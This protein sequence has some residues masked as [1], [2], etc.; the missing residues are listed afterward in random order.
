MISIEA[1]AEGFT[2]SADGR[3]VLSHTRKRPCIELGRSENLVRQSRGSFRLRRR[4]TDSEALKSYKVVEASADLAIV[5]FEGKLRVAARWSEGRLRLSFSQFDSRVDFFRLRLA[6]WPDERI[7][8]CGERFDALDLKLSR[9]KLWVHRKG[10]GRGREFLSILARSRSPGGAG[11]WRS[12]CPVPAFVS[13][14]DYWCA[15]DCP[16]YMILDFRRNLTIVESWAVP[17]EIVMGFQAEASAAVADMASVYGRPPVPPYWTFE[18]ACLGVLGGRE[19]LERKLGTVLEAGAKVSAVFAQDWREGGLYP[20]LGGLVA[21]LRSRGIRFIGYLSPLLDVRGDLYAEASRERLCIKDSEGRDYLIEPPPGTSASPL[22]MLDFT[23]DE[24]GA[25]MKD[26]IRRELLG[27][28]MSGWMADSGEYLPADAVLASGEDARLAHNRWPVFWAR[29]N[30]EAFEESGRAGDLL[31]FLRSGWLGSSRYA[32]AFWAGDQL[33]D[34]SRDGLAGLVPAALSLGLSGGG[35]WHS[36]TGGSLC[37]AGARR[38]PECLARWMEMSAFTPFFRGREGSRPKDSAQFWSD[39]ASLSLF[40][41]L[42][43]IYAALKPYHLAVAAE[44]AELGLPPIRHPWMH[45]ERDP[46]AQRLCRQYLYGRD[47]M[48]APALAPGIQLT[49][50]YLP[51]DEWVHL[52]SSRVFRS[53]RVAVESP[54]GY[55]A[56]FYRSASPFA[57]LFDALRRTSRRS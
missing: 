50:A 41:R 30:R 36:D 37:L 7:F 39:P 54:L 19:A 2:L 17:R 45:Y 12:P 27:I 38:R 44:Q 47:L 53:G 9:V 35:F 6:A 55:P 18:G 56:V 33:A 15:I 10:L 11:R 52:W 57:S 20:D 1:G 21:A 24:A 22:A 48:V 51:E 16:A 25:W 49:E 14:K 4:R 13:T 3:R 46:L 31:F 23:K 32:T 34:F 26:F 40:A 28:G 8:G 5:D 42:S 43:D 29:I